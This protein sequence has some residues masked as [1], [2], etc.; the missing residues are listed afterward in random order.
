VDKS[1][2][3]KGKGR[4]S[5]K[6]DK[7]FSWI[8]DGYEDGVGSVCI[9]ELKALTK[10]AQLAYVG[11]NWRESNQK[12]I[13]AVAMANEALEIINVAHSAF[14]NLPVIPEG[15]RLANDAY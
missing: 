10:S 14:D 11:E 7:G 3:G 4:A 2:E 13:D 5:A 15:G 12:Y 6:T 1:S 8:L 9:K